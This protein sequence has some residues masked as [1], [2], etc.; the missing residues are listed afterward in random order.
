MKATNATSLSLQLRLAKLGAGFNALRY[1]NYRLY[2]VGQLISIIGT[3][4]QSTAQAWLVFQMTGSAFSLGLVTT[5]QFLPVMLFSLIGGVIVDRLPKRRLM[6]ITQSL[7]LI[8]AAIFGGL[9]ASGAIQIWHIYL[10]A[11][12]QG[13]VN[14]VDNPARQAFPI[15]LVAR[16]DT[17]NAVAL[18]SMLFNGARIIGPAIAGIVIATAGVAPALFLNAVSF[19]AVI[20]ALAMMNPKGFYVRPVRQKQAALSDLVEGLSYARRST[21]VLTIL[22][23]IGVIGTF[24]YNFSTVLPLIGGFVLH[25]WRS[26]LRRII[27]CVGN[28][29]FRRGIV[30]RLCPEHIHQAPFHWFN[31]L[32]SAARSIITL[33]CIHTVGRDTNR[34]GICWYSVH[35]HRQHATAN[36]CA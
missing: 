3:W 7:L 10:L 36:Q 31:R 26:R 24:G 6:M 23:V 17:G 8:Q 12:L 28:W 16:E 4:M 21:V 25:T 20:F 5:L 18:N 14:V 35:Y 11:A 27:D 19:I 15:E 29:F 1:R 13:M 22:I 30:C 2:W 32:Q 33:Q 34:P 9:V